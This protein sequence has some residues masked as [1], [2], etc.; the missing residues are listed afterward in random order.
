MLDSKYFMSCAA[1]F[2]NVVKFFKVG[3]NE[4]QRTDGNL[5]DEKRDTRK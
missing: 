4:F 3:I 1:S 5:T 2:M